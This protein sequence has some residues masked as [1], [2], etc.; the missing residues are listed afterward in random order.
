VRLYKVENTKGAEIIF[1]YHFSDL[2][3]S[4]GPVCVSV[5]LDNNLELTAL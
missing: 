3:R 2:D 5:C 4:I 1:A